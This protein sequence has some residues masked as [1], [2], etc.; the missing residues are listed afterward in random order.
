MEPWTPWILR[1]VW[2]CVNAKRQSERLRVQLQTFSARLVRNKFLENQEK[3][4]RDTQGI[5]GWNHMHKI[6]AEFVV[7]RAECR[8]AIELI[9]HFPPPP[10]APGC[11]TSR[12]NNVEDLFLLIDFVVVG[13]TRL[14]FPP[15]WNLYI[16]Q[17]WLFSASFSKKYR[18][19]MRKW[20]LPKVK[21]IHLAHPLVAGCS[22]GHKPRPLDVSRQNMDQ[23]LEVKVHV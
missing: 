5:P 12:R 11:S 23:I 3:S 22:I 6:F 21:P 2:T 7:I 17:W 1:V 9:Y 19:D 4:M 20:Q 13:Q 8:G 14:L 18:L 16:K 10:A 15:V